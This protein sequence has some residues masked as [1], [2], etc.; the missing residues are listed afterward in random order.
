MLLT[1]CIAF[2]R[3]IFAKASLDYRNRYEITLPSP[4]RLSPLTRQLLY[5]SNQLNSAYFLVSDLP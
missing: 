3:A 1:I 5:H 4:G 2:V